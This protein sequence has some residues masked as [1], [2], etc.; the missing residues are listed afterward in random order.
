MS[1]T[2]LTQ[3]SAVAARHLRVGVRSLFFNGAPRQSIALKNKDLA[4]QDLTPK[5]LSTRSATARAIDDSLRLRAALEHYLS[6]G[7]V[8]IDNNWIE[9][10]I[11]PIAIGR[12][13]WLFA[14]SLRAGRRV[15]AV[16]SSI[17]SAKLNG[18]DPLVYLT[19]VL[20]RFAHAAE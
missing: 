20:E 17:H 5:T 14:G 10:Q 8:P 7:R 11:R 4:P 19:D 18:H 2:D 12:K 13:N 9:N 3:R 15:A 1:S 6:D 16:M